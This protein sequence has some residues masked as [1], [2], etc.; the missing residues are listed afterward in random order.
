MNLC[1]QAIMGLE[2]PA[3]SAMITKHFVIIFSKT[4]NKKLYFIFNLHIFFVMAYPL[5][6][7][8]LFVLKILSAFYICCILYSN[9]KSD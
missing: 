7:Q 6:G 9:T 8:L 1:E 4:C 2:L 3:A 5:A